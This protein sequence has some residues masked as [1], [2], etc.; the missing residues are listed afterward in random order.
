MMVEVEKQKSDTDI[1]I[2]K[3]SK[4]SNLAAEEQAIANEE[5]E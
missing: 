1:L 5:E 3:V 4:E 2:D